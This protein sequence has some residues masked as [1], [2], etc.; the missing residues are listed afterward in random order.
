VDPQEGPPPRRRRRFGRRL[1]LWS[2]VLGAAALFYVDRQVVGGFDEGRCRQRVRV[3]GAPRSHAVGT[4]IERAEIEKD[5]AS[6][7]YRR[8]SGAPSQ[9]G[10]YRRTRDRLAIHL[11]RAPLA[12]AFVDRAEQLVHL[13]LSSG[14]VSDIV[15]PESDTRADSI[16]LDPPLLEG[17]FDDHWTARASLRLGDLPPHVV[18]AVLAAEDQRFLSHPGLDFGSL[19][20]AVRVNWAAGE[21]RQGGSTITQQLVKNHFLTQDRTFARKLREIPMALALEWRY[22]KRDILEC[23]LATVYLGHD[24]LVGVYGFAEASRV[25]FGKPASALTLGEA[26]TIAGMIRAPNALS[27][28]RH[29]ERARARRDQVLGQLEDLGWITPA[30]AAAARAERLPRPPLR[31]APPEAYFLRHVRRELEA[32]SLAP[33]GLRA[34]SAIFTTLDVRLQRIADAEVR[35]A[36]QRL[37][38]RRGG[39]RPVQMAVVALEPASGAVRALVGGRDYL[40]SQLDRATQVR[41]PV[42]SLFKP[43]VY[44]AAIADRELGLTPASILR[45]EPIVQPVSAGSWSPQNHDQRF[46][47]PV[48]MREALEDSLNVPA[49]RLAEDLGI[50]RVAAFGDR[51]ALGRGGLPRV[52]AIAL[53]AFN[54]S[55]LDVATSYG[56]FAD[57]GEE[58]RPRFVESVEAPSGAAV[59]RTAPSATRIVDADSAY[60]VHAML[61]GVFERGTARGARAAGLT[62][63][64]AGKTGT[65]NDYR[66]AWIVGYTPTLLLAVWVGYDDDRP[67]GGSASQIALPVW[68]AIMRRALAGEPVERVPVPRG[69]ELVKVEAATGLRA[70]PG[71]GPAVTGAFLRGT[72]PRQ[73]CARDRSGEAAD[74]AALPEPLREAGAL[75]DRVIEAIRR[76][77]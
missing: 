42:G 75:V 21:V 3:Y 49:V 31:A 36:V 63:P 43:F 20:R 50:E 47:G 40:K 14:R 4:Q 5:L 69:V 25:Y 6:L 55:L 44:L 16:A 29:P 60:V 59:L 48:T 45:D 38:A 1:A 23:Y 30:Q 72:A 65:T 39:R 51:L 10:T 64:L 27:P 77:W 52:P 61:E 70:G 24:R 46:R 18:D 33:E 53:G 56:I 17:V 26:A 57:R 32:R 19:M 34:G 2:I 13:E 68:T 7:G 58:V 37:D 15:F 66:D 76:S 35:E 12:D 74:E 73:S 28:L 22:P 9:P 71:C 41:R 11:R 8:V 62:Q 67:V 54:A